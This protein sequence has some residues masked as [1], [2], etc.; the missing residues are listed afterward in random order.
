MCFSTWKM[1]LCGRQ[2]FYFINPCIVKFNFRNRLFIDGAYYIVN[3]IEN[4]NP[5]ELTSTNVELVKLLETE[6]F[7]PQQFKLSDSTSISSGVDVQNY[8]LNSS[9]NVGTNIQNRGS[10]CLA[11]GENI[12]IP[13][14]CNN[15]IVFGNNIT[16][17]ENSTGL[18]LNYKS[19]VALISQTGTAAPTAI[20]LENTLGTLTFTYFGVG[21][22]KVATTDSLF[23]LNKTFLLIENS[24]NS[25]NSL[26]RTGVNDLVISCSDLL[27]AAVNGTLNKTSIEIRIY[28]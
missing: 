4:Y 5:L 25:N 3:K 28:Y 22:Y 9:L 7:T 23:T 19:Y 1:L 24:N 12:I 6:V 16:A 20:V 11:V 17:D 10:N 21:V 26:F 15:L 8:R 14:S 27:G 13:A 18:L 2:S